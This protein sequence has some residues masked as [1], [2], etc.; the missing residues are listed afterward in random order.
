MFQ[1]KRCYTLV[2]AELNQLRSVEFWSKSNDENNLESGQYFTKYYQINM[3]IQKPYLDAICDRD[4]KVQQKGLQSAKGWWITKC[5]KSVLQIAM[6]VRLQ[7]ATGWLQSVIV[8]TICAMG[9]QSVMVPGET[10]PAL[11]GTWYLEI[12]KNNY[13]I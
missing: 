3:K 6:C 7:S 12:E 11:F 5:D 8:I 9:L 13:P 2:N 1:S 10:F 4:C